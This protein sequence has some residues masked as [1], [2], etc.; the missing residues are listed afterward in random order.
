MSVEKPVVRIENWDI[1]EQNGQEI[2]TG[3]VYGDDRY[4]DGDKIR[5]SVVTHIETKNTIYQL[6]KHFKRSPVPENPE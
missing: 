2:L 6:G 5:T 4:H 1:I 3:N